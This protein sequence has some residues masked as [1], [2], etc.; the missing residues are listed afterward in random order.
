MPVITPNSAASKFIR[1]SIDKTKL[2]VSKPLIS[3]EQFIDLL[4]S[5]GIYTRDQIEWYTKFNRFGCLDPYN[6]VTTTREYIFIT[7]P[8]LHI[9]DGTSQSNLN[10]ELEGIP[11]WRDAFTRYKD[12]LGQLQYSANSPRDVFVNL[13]SNCIKSTLDLPGVSS[14]E[15]DTNENIYGTHMTYRRSSLTSDEHHDFSLEFEDT[16]YLEIYA[17]FKLYD[18]YS[19]LKDLG[20][21]TPVYDSYIEDKIL[22]DQMAAYKFIVGEDGETLLYWAK[23]WG[24]YPKSV[25]REAFSDLSNLS[26]GLRFSVNFH[27]IFVDDLDPTILGEFNELTLP[28]GTLPSKSE[29]L[30]IYNFDIGAV[31][32]RWA[33][34]PFIV[35]I[36]N[37]VA[38]NSAIYKLKWGL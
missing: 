14:N 31:D 3:D 27:S 1:D 36:R 5:A 32:G 2:A 16:K 20:M 28:S 18:L 7:K 25:P 17:W 12:V 11:I 19:Q 29:I 22:Y 10:P 34:Y 15:I 24:L 23:L 9:F 4:N 37:K 6:N 13:F 21:V 35:K 26:N 8:D 38:N 33:S 30:P